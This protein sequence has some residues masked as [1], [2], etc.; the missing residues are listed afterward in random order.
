MSIKEILNSIYNKNIKL[1]NKDLENID[2]Y[3]SNIS[4]ENKRKIIEESKINISYV[5]HKILKI[6]N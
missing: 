2:P 5:L 3:D 6:K 1:Y 4:I